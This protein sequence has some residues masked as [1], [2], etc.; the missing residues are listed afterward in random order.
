MRFVG[1][2][3]D[4]E[5]FSRMELKHSDF[6]ETLKVEAAPCPRNSHP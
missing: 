4:V 5:P 2:I 1:Q 6:S 3:T